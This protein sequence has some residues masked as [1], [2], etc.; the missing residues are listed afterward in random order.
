MSGSLQYRFI[1]VTRKTRL[2][3]LIERFNT[4]P[5]ARFYLEHN[6]VDAQDYLDEHDLYQSRL[7]EAERILKAL[8]RFQLLERR[9]LPNYQFS[10]ADIV[11]TVGQDGL[12]ANTLKY[13]DG[14]PVIAINPD[15]GR[16]DGKLLPF[17]I[18]DLSAAVTRTVAGKS[19]CKTISFAEAKT[20]DG[21]RMLA[22]NDLFIGPRSH[23]S[24]RYLL[25]WD[26]RR[27]IQS[28][29]GIIVSTG[30]GSTGWFQSIL[31]GAMS[32]AGSDSHPLKDG[33]AWQERRLQFTVREPFPS[34]TTGVNLVF[35]AIT[36]ETPLTLESQMPENGVIFSD[37]IETDFLAFN[38][39]TVAT[40]GL[41][42]T[43]G[44]LIV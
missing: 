18:G 24:A 27:E 40:I 1:L 35:G 31:A 12:V 10:P 14:Q 8:G 36:P 22:V 6:Q 34:R 26:G 16:W 20:N 2:Q 19:A 25:S 15:P 33:F 28:S 13:L 30:F 41:A 3:E 7:Q 11:V 5:Q 38:S 9:L 37:G 21:Q 42:A 43:Q 32:V 44:Q 23:T 17:E 4:W 39:G 29:S